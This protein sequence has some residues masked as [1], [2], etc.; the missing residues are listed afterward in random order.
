MYEVK[1]VNSEWKKKKDQLQGL[2]ITP[3]L[4]KYEALV[5]VIE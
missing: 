4:H 1:S 2:L 3:L 5:P